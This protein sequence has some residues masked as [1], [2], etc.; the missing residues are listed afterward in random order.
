MLRCGTLW[1]G[2]RRAALLGCIACVAWLAAEIAPAIAETACMLCCGML[3]LV[4]LC[5]VMEG[6]TLVAVPWTQAR[7]AA[8]KLGSAFIALPSL[9][10]CC[11]LLA[12]PLPPIKSPQLKL[13]TGESPNAPP[14][15]PSS[16]LP[17]ACR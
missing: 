1:S 9:H 7:H 10:A 13:N 6:S 16:D 12:L 5:C 4:I 2:L 8:L 15:H 14:A 17:P 3:H 11:S